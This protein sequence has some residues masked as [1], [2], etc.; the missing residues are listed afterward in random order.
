MNRLKKTDPLK[1]DEIYNKIYGMANV[2]YIESIMLSDEG[3][4]EIAESIRYQMSDFFFKME[5]SSTAKRVYK[6]LENLKIILDSLY[7]SLMEKKIRNRD[8]I[9]IK[10][11]VM[12]L[13]NLISDL[14]DYQLTN[15]NYTT[16]KYYSPL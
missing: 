3:C 7:G 14:K 1:L 2:I 12:V 4:V 5:K 16:T 10:Q 13:V 6:G 15:N 11:H 8:Y 9:R